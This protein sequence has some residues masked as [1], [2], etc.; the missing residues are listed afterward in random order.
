MS[1]Q[2]LEKKFVYNEGDTYHNFFLISGMFKKIFP[3]RVVNSIYFDTEKEI[4]N[5][6]AA[7]CQDGCVAVVAKCELSYMKTQLRPSLRIVVT[8]G[9]TDEDIKTACQVINKAFETT[10]GK[11]PS[12][13]TCLF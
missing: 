7:L 12:L 13:C 9:L 3:K 11:N 4:M 1:I 6:C 2:R 10:V 8:S 5:T